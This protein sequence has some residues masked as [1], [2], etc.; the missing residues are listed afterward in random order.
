MAVSRAKRLSWV[1][2]PAVLA[3]SACAPV[4]SK[5]GYLPDPIA[6]AGIVLGKDTKQS[7]QK[8]LGDPSTRATFD[9]DNWYYISSEQQQVAFFDPTVLKSSILAV[10]FNKDDTVQGI[11]H[12]S[13]KDGHVV[14]FETRTTPTPGRE[15]TFLQQLLS[16][17]PGVPTGGSGGG[18]GGDQRNPG[19]GG[20]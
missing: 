7:I 13:L 20:H 15:L 6:E 12:Y 9:G 3:A 8:K 2:L 19:G 17:T 1:L 16:S 5:R 11:R 18:I 10:H 4:I 14:A